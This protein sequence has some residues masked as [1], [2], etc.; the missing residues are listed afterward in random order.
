[1]KPKSDNGV[2]RMVRWNFDIPPSAAS[3]FVIAMRAYHTEKDGRK[4]EQIAA[5]QA[6]ILNAL[7]PP[8]LKRMTSFEVGE[9]FKLMKGQ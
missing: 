8:E 9:V 1:M 5:R 7:L 2:L 3:E 6:E 4:R